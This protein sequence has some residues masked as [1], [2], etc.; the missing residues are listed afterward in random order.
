MLRKQRLRT[1]PLIL[2]ERDVLASK[3]RR[4]HRCRLSDAE[5]GCG[6]PWLKM[7][8][9]KSSEARAVRP[10]VRRLQ[11]CGEAGE[12]LPRW[13]LEQAVN[14]PF[15]CSLTSLVP[16]R[17]TLELASVVSCF[18]SEWDLVVR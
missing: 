5:N 15:F 12:V 6:R 16:F 1:A 17:V 11:G 2:R 18:L 9:N 14:P 10:V 8:E 7:S 3:H 4:V 13:L